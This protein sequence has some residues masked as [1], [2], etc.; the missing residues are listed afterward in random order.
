MQYCNHEWFSV[1]GHPV[2][3]FENVD[4]SSV[5]SEDGLASIDRH[6]DGLVANRQS[7]RFQFSLRRTWSREDGVSGPAFVLVSA[8]PELREDGS[9][10]A[11]AGTLTDVSHLKWAESVQKM[12]TDEA[13]E[14]KRQQDFF[15]DM[16]SHEVSLA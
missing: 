2:V 12:R 10:R 8:Y 3:P 15:T 1:T 14:A 11:I 13:V 9:V 6:W 5:V 7:T 16:T 4:W